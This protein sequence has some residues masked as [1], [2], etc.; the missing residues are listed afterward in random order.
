MIILALLVVMLC[1]YYWLMVGKGVVVL[2]GGQQCENLDEQGR[3]HWY[4]RVIEVFP[5]VDI[6]YCAGRQRAVGLGSVMMY[7][8]W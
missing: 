8:V 2:Q 4:A 5:M 3:K 1:A 6:M 7:S